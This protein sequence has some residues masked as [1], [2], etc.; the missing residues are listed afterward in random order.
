MICGKCGK[1]F[2]KKVYKLHILECKIEEEAKKIE[3]Y[4]RKELFE[5]C[6]EMG[7]TDYSTK[8]NSDLIEMINVA[9]KNG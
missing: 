9:D 3:D 4:T 7:L 1:V 6:K 5:K 2:S 8:S